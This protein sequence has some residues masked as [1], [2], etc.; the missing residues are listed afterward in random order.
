MPRLTLQAKSESEH[1]WVLLDG[2]K[3]ISLRDG[4]SEGLK[5][6]TTWLVD[7][8]EISNEEA[9]AVLGMTVRTVE[10]YQA[11]YAERGN[12][13]DV[14][15][16]R[17]FNGGQQTDYRMEGHK[18][19]LV[20]QSTLNLVKGTKN[21]ERGL[22]RQLKNV[23][24][25]RTIGRQRQN[26]GW[27]AAEEAGLGEEVADYIKAK[28]LEAYY[29]GVAGE[30]VESV[31]GDIAPGEWQKPQRGLVGAALG[32]AH[33]AINGTYESL[34]RLVDK[35]LTVL[36][37]WSPLHVFHILLVYLMTSGGE[38]L[39]QIKYFAWG[40]V[41]G[42]I[43]CA[44]LS[45][46]S[47]R[48]WMIAVAEYAK[49]KVTVHRS[50]GKQESMTRLQDYQEESIAQ[51]LKRGLIRGWAIFLDDYI[52]AIYRREPIAR[53][54]HGTRKGCPK[55]FRCHTAQDVDT[56]HAVTCLLGVSD[57]TPL[58]VI[59]RVTRRINGGLDRVCPGWKLELVIADRWWSVETVISWVLQVGMKLL[60]W[61]KDTKTI[62]D[63]LETVSND[64]L[65]QHPLTVEV[66]DEA[67]GEVVDQVI[68]YRLDTHL[69]IYDLE[70]PVRCIIEWD[71]DPDSK[72]VVRLLVGD[73]KSE[74]DEEQV[75]DDL[76]FRQRVEIM[77]KKLQRRVNWSA[78]GG[79]EAH[80]RPSELEMPDAEGRQR[81]LKNRRQVATRQTNNQARLKEVEQE[82]ERL[83]QGE[84]ASNGLNLGIQDL[85]RLAKN[86]KNSIQ[87]ATT[88]LNEL[89][90]ILN[91]AKGN[92]S[93]PEEKPVAE[94]GL[95][96]ESILTQLKLDVFTAQETLIDNYIEH[97]L[98]PVLR[99]EAEQ[100]AA[101]RQRRDK[102]STAKGRVGQ[103]LSTAVEELYQIKLDNLERE[104]ILLRLL[105][106]R[107]DFVLHKTKP[108]VLVIVDPFD[109]HR[110]QAAFER[111]CSILNQHDIRIPLARGEMWRL[112]F[113]YRLDAPSSSAR[114]K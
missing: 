66:L 63:A 33:L 76:R 7:S 96:R 32:A 52:K 85:N 65:K 28:Q 22:A 82:V 60:V 43:G 92:A 6:V 20:R 5:A 110:M 55:S 3:L 106:Q 2:E 14:M 15:D 18:K 25:D 64:D 90:G 44:G 86:L 104:T 27:R 19:E 37:Q 87:R 109:D 100:Q 98:K 45:A 83:R 46:T 67:T 59:Q 101:V 75:V 111:Y 21:S 8:Q 57:V 69:S 31:V 36:K 47:L 68:G 88:R 107:G 42:L 108:I 103:P 35:R 23:V 112:L 99:K 89:D 9:A 53:A 48:N 97:G 61:G 94:L 105:N 79:G 39:S 29:A 17:H 81:L 113:T 30:P 54:K 50:D 10:G 114:F 62:Q 49:E 72:K 95:E 91:W 41:R 26:T 56:G 58:T 11:R 71:G 38:R 12:S 13:A 51:R 40:Q 70:K 16:R 34:K 78:F 24:G 77:L 84:P 80:E 4:D 93:R 1:I 102:R 74:L 73:E